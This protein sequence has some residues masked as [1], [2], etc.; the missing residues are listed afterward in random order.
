MMKRGL[1][2]AILLATA[3]FARPDIHWFNE[4]TNRVTYATGGT[5]YLFGS[6]TD[7][8][9]GCLVQLIYAGPDGTNNPAVPTGD[10]V[11]GDDVVADKRW[12]GA[13]VLQVDRN[14][15]LRYK[16]TPGITGGLYYVRAW[17]APAA[18]YGGGL[19]PTSMTNFYGD[20]ALWSF[21]GTVVPPGDDDR[22][23]FGGAGGFAANRIPGADSN[24]NGIPDWWEFLYFRSITGAVASADSDTDFTDNLG[25]YI[26]GTVPTNASSVFTLLS[27]SGVSTD[28]VVVQWSSVTGRVYSI[29]RCVAVTNW[30]VLDTNLTSGS[31]IRSYTNSVGAAGLFLYRVR[32][33]PP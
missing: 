4:D 10:G 26:A 24:T 22:F 2:I 17:T 33:T 19:V 25:E 20:S 8:T 29:D 13:N 30:T 14:G 11:T 3:P 15:Y 32:V 21:P 1:T 12:I 5:D 28:A 27:V 16:L 9:A 7:S 31:S 23:N 18:E 6:Q